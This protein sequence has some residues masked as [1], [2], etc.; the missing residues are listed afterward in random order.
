MRP[1]VVLLAVFALFALAQASVSCEVGVNRLSREC[2]CFDA[3]QL[4]VEVGCRI[5]DSPFACGFNESTGSCGF[6]V[7][8][9]GESFESVPEVSLAAD[10]STARSCNVS[11]SS[12]ELRRGGQAGVSITCFDGSFDYSTWKPTGSVTACPNVSWSS[13]PSLGV[14]SPS[15]SERN[16]SALLSTVFKASL[17][18]EPGVY[19]SGLQARFSTDAD[20]YCHAHLTVLQP[21]GILLP[22]LVVESVVP[23]DVFYS[24]FDVNGDSRV[25]R[26]DMWLVVNSTINARPSCLDFGGV[27]KCDF[28]GDWTVNIGDLGLFTRNVFVFRRFSESGGPVNVSVKNI[29]LAPANASK[30]R[31]RFSKHDGGLQADGTSFVPSVPAGGFYSSRILLPQLQLGEGEYV[32]DVF[33]DSDVENVELSK[34]NNSLS[35]KF[36]VS[37]GAVPPQR[38]D[39]VVVNI[40]PLMPFL[41]TGGTLLVEV[42]NVGQGDSPVWYLGGSVWKWGGATAFSFDEKVKA[43]SA[44]EST[45]VSVSVPS[46]NYSWLGLGLYAV[47]VTANT[48]WYGSGMPVESNA[49]NNKMFTTFNVSLPAQFSGPDLVVENLSVA[50]NESRV[51]ANFTVKNS[52]TAA[53]NASA[54][55]FQVLDKQGVVL[56]DSEFAVPALSAGQ[57]RALSLDFVLFGGNYSLR[58]SADY[59]ESNAELNELNNN[60]ST[61]FTVAGSAPLPDLVV[62]R[63]LAGAESIN[64]TVKNVGSVASNASMLRYTISNDASVLEGGGRTVLELSPGSNSSLT[65]SI[66]RFAASFYYFN[67][68]LDFDQKNVELNESNNNAS[69]RFSILPDTRVGFGLHSLRL[70]DAVLV[71]GFTYNFSDRTPSTA[72][73]RVTSSQ[74]VVCELHSPACVYSAGVETAE[75]VGLKGITGVSL[76]VVSLDVSSPT[77]NFQSYS[78]STPTPFATPTPVVLKADLVP[79]NASLAS[80]DASLGIARFNA[81]FSN[82][83]GASAAAG[84][85][86]SVQFLDALRNPVGAASVAQVS[87]LAANGNSSVELPLRYNSINRSSVRFVRVGVD[88][89]S[90]VSESLES[91]NVADFAFSFTGR[92]A[93]RSDA[94]TDRTVFIVSD[95]DWKTVLKLVPVSTWWEGAVLKKHPLLVFHEE[96]NSFDADSLIY[97]LQQYRPDRIYVVGQTPQDF[98]RLL[99]AAEPVGAGVQQSAVV[100]L[101]G[102]DASLLG[103]WG[104]FDSNV[105]VREGEFSFNEVSLSLS[106]ALLENGTYPRSQPVVGYKYYPSNASLEVSV[107]QAYGVDGFVNVSLPIGAVVQSRLYEVELTTS[108]D[109]DFAGVEFAG[110]FKAVPIRS[111]SFRA[112][113]K[114]SAPTQVLKILLRGDSPDSSPVT[115]TLSINS[116]VV[117]EIDLG[118]YPNALTAAQASALDNLPLVFSTAGPDREQERIALEQRLSGR[119]DSSKVMML[120]PFDLDSSLSSPAQGFTPE[121]SSGEVVRT[122]F[123]DSLIAPVLSAAKKEPMLFVYPV[124]PEDGREQFIRRSSTLSSKQYLTIFG[125]PNAIPALVQ[126][127][128]SADAFV[129]PDLNKDGF[130]ELMAGRVYGIS[131]SDVS[132]YVARVLFADRLEKVQDFS[133]LLNFNDDWNGAVIPQKTIAKTAQ[134]VLTQAGAQS[135]SFFTDEDAS[136]ITPDKLLNRFYVNYLNHGSATWTGFEWWSGMRDKWL[137]PSVLLVTA[138]SSCAF[139]SLALDRYKLVCA[140]ALRKGV[141]AHFGSVQ[142]SFVGDHPS[143]TLPEMLVEGK[144]LGEVIKYY[145]TLI[146]S[147]SDVGYLQLLGDPTISIQDV[148]SQPLQNTLTLPV[149]SSTQGASP[150]QGLYRTTATVPQ[151]PVNVFVRMRSKLPSVSNADSD[152]AQT[153]AGKLLDNQFAAY[154]YT[155]PES[156]SNVFSQYLYLPFEFDGDYEPVQGAI[157]RAGGQPELF[158]FSCLDESYCRAS[159]NTDAFSIYRHKKEGRWIATIQRSGNSAFTSSVPVE[160]MWVDW[161]LA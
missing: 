158:S 49:N 87:S 36:N 149:I 5:F 71:N 151:L 73:F 84:F 18:A 115:R 2:G 153:P 125:S 132:S 45:V 88:V 82:V 150:N 25:D 95:V 97:F 33:L 143:T 89:G 121:K 52:G 8:G 4:D 118:A 100:R 96:A 108:G 144:T 6:L 110:T 47:E 160:E 11:P 78:P 32:L 124:S 156:G 60:A 41:V 15:L 12:V 79:L 56:K 130:P 1:L 123:K 46:L 106:S 99:V 48:G 50:F 68:S 38:P 76:F 146:R 17:S 129:Y 113:F 39:L 81:S 16:G 42:K 147:R 142:E 77:F 66:P 59:R 148:R 114:P 65:V 85:S 13:L 94:Y 122:F 63:L 90:V 75:N 19:Y 109:Y 102:D 119:L 116:V 7:Q 120:N 104:A 126:E 20:Y 27:A 112:V 14:F 86:V 55:L 70:F 51:Y 131:L 10:G 64:V 44:S 53:S 157:T 54:L 134:Q 155:V 31:Y 93:R 139:E 72:A 105:S 37:A 98:D 107:V 159:G 145:A 69:L 34:A 29:G 140:Q 103:F 152:Y 128:F 83:G 24:R 22:D 57:W 23:D 133:V 35:A 101:S 80:D 154:N 26:T 161:R 3:G 127:V 21:Q 74:G 9:T 58:V 136:T 67:V 117:T 62:E 138:C 91:N 40:T 141:L 30:L 111:R 92:T 61:L 135:R 28:N 137:K 43:L